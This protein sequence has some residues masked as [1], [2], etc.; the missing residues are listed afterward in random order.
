[1]PETITVAHAALFFQIVTSLS[2]AG[3]LIYGGIQ[4][5]EAR[6]AAHVANFIKLVEM[7]MELRRMRVEDP[8]LAAVYSHDMIGLENDE[9]VRQYF[10]NLMQL[11]L[12]EIAWYSHKLDQLPDDYYN[13]WVSRMR[14]LQSEKSYQKMVHSPSMKILHDEFQQLVTQMLKEHEA[15]AAAN[16]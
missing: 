12:F 16:S 1:M 14:T 7:Q 15:A 2:I 5:R 11:S 9:D 13:S 4:F 3:G 6:K 8:R 10:F